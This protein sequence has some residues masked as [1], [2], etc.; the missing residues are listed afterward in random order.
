[1]YKLLENTLNSTTI[2]I[3]SPKDQ[4]IILDTSISQC[5]K[6]KFYVQIENGIPVIEI[7]LF[8]DAKILSSA[9]K[10]EN[11]SESDLNTVRNAL[12]SKIS[13]EMY[14]YL[15][16]I[17]KEYNSDINGFLGILTRNYIDLDS[18]KDID[19]NKMFPEAKFMV[20]VNLTLDSNHL[21]PRY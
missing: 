18:M 9:S 13:L 19:W 12:E 11:I 4:N 2:S 5:K 1:M 20:N 15:N 6:S 8:L 17:S 14:N 3:V 16:S 10:D 21:F 7:N